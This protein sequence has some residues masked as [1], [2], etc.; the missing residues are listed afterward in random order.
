MRSGI[1]LVKFVFLGSL[2][3]LQAI[4]QTSSSAINYGF[5]PR[6]AWGDLTD[7]I[8][9]SQELR[10]GDI[11]Y[12]SA[13]PQPDGTVKVEVMSPP[14][15]TK[16]LLLIST[17]AKN[18]SDKTVYLLADKTKS[19]TD[20]PSFLKVQVKSLT[21]SVRSLNVHPAPLLSG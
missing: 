3:I 4:G 18:I 19:G 1:I 10:F 12:T 14:P 2:F 16:P 21:G 8:K 17:I 9:V 11:P 13:N 6:N 5:T 15:G 20:N 7:G